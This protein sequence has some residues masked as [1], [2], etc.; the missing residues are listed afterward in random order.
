MNLSPEERETIIRFD[1]TKDAASVFTC[2]H[3]VWDRLGKIK[4]FKLI[5][6][7]RLDGEICGKEFE[8]P[9]SFVRYTKGGI[10]VAAPKKVSETQREA[11]KANVQRAILSRKSTQPVYHT[12]K[13]NDLK[14]SRQGR[15]I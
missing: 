9:R 12:E 15:T 5:R 13:A 11:S 8:C 10:T 14:G 1:A 2:Q 7:E 6:T 4:G 3:E